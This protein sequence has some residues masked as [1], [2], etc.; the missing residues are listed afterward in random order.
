MNIKGILWA[1]QHALLGQDQG[2]FPISTLLIHFVFIRHMKIGTHVEQAR[3]GT[4]RNEAKMSS[5]ITSLL[6]S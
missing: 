6:F 4:Q 2:H 5:S 1:T 3:S